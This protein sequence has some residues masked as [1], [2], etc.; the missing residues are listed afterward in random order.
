MSD[1]DPQ[2][3]AEALDDDR[4]DGEYPPESPLG[5]D[6]YGTT[7]AEERWDEPLA[8]R[9]AR[10]EPDDDRARRDL[11]E[12]EGL[13]ALDDGD[14]LAGDDTLRDVAQEREAPVPAEEDAVHVVG[15]D[16]I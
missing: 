9:V 4:L 14:P 16:E 1:T 7:G 5:V 12:V 15:D 10:E 13:G 11:P 8:E 2:D 3:E 6:A